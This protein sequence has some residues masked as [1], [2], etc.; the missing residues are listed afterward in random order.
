M[1]NCQ[2]HKI[3]KLTQRQ[4]FSNLGSCAC[5]LHKL[6]EIHKKWLPSIF[7]KKF[8]SFFIISHDC[9][10]CVETWKTRFYFYDFCFDVH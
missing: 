4:R 6:I 5:R 10:T 3:D 9:T 2:V 7:V 1:S 8:N